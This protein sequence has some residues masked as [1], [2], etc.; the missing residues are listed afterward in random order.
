MLRGRR[1]EGRRVGVVLRDGVVYGWWRCRRGDRG[2]EEG[3]VT[4]E[5]R[6]EVVGAAPL[7]RLGLAFGGGCGRDEVG[8]CCTLEEVSR[9][10]QGVI[11][12]DK[13]GNSTVSRR[14]PSGETRRRYCNSGNGLLG[15]SSFLL[16][17]VSRASNVWKTAI[18]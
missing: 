8:C 15:R 6:G 4:G 2:V 12:Q 1:A 17:W 16:I 9:S 18:G 10:L 7:L 14:N 13:P 11:E 5:E 3:E